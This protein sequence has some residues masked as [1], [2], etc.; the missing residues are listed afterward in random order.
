MEYAVRVG[1]GAIIHRKFYKDWFRH[2]KV[3][4]G[5]GVAQTDIHIGRRSHK[6]TLGKGS[7]K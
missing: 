1:S 3:N 6:P 7:L 4:R 2:S 5:R